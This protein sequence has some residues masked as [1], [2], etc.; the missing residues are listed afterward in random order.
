MDDYF[1][2]FF[3]KFGKSREENLFAE[4]FTEFAKSAVTLNAKIKS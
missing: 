1:F 2:L 4:K 3:F